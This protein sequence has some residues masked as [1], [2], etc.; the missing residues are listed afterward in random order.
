MIRYD[1]LFVPGDPMHIPPTPKD[2]RTKLPHALWKRF[3][4]MEL[5]V[6]RF[7]VRKI[8][9]LMLKDQKEER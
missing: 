3:D 4:S 6:P 8:S 5:P 1:G 9:F 2:P 7:K